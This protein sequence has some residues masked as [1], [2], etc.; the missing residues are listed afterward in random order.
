MNWFQCSMIK[1][2]S[3]FILFNNNTVLNFSLQVAIHYCRE[4]MSELVWLEHRLE[5]R[6]PVVPVLGRLIFSILILGLVPW[7]LNITFQ[8]TQWEWEIHSFLNNLLLVPH[9]SLIIPAILSGILIVCL[10]LVLLTKHLIISVTLIAKGV[11]VV[12]GLIEVVVEV[13]I[14]TLGGGIDNRLKTI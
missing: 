11:P 2:M 7:V 8:V 14:Q 4:Q 12:V 10:L 3:T 6:N 13:V 5:N 1:K 9:L